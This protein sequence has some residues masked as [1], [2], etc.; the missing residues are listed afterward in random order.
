VT[1]IDPEKW[2]DQ[3]GD[4]LYRFALM[5]VGEPAVAEDLVQEALCS[6]LASKDRF[7]GKSSEKTWLI[8]ILKHKIA[9][10]FRKSSREVTGIESF[11]DLASDEDEF[12]DTRGRWR[13]PPGHWKGS[14]DDLLQNKEFWEIFHRCLDGLSK[15][16]RQAFALRELD[17]METGDICKVLGITPTNLWVA[18]HRA[19]GGLRN[20]LERNWFLGP[21]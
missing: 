21:E 18:L 4:A 16:L 10:Y 15:G 1:A 5:R 20:C 12:F 6:A 17:G 13:R 2:I 3:C 11:D 14:P 8:G 7:S 19:R 9:D